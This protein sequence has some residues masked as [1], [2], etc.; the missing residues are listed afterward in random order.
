MTLYRTF[1]NIY[2]GANLSIHTWLKNL[3]AV[4][5]SEGG[6]LPDTIYAQID[7]GVE[8]AN[9]TM[10]GI[11]ELLVSR[12]LTRKVVLT[13]LPVGHTHEDIDSVFGKI[14]K[15][16]E[17]RAANVTEYVADCMTD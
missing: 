14:W 15:Y 2:N 10:K 1:N 16:L 8:N 9:V 12:R 17:G 5:D 7:G 11:C 6:R 3:E 4:Y 13:R